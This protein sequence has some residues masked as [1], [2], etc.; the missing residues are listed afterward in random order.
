PDATPSAPS[1]RSMRAPR[2]SAP[3]P[4]RTRPRG[5]RP[6]LLL[7]AAALAAAPA[8]A[9]RAQPE[10]TRQGLLVPTF[11]VDSGLDRDLGPDVA[12]AVRDRLGD[13]LP[14]REVEVIGG[15]KIRTT[16]TLSGFDPR[17]A[18]DER[19]LEQLAR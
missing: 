11:A 10:F 2:V 12:E 1:R 6:A 18:P 7:V 16:L 14:E 19:T 5:A 17:V 15:G 4:R 8:A 9:Q 13:R 3:S